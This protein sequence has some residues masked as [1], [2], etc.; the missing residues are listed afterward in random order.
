MSAETR[1]PLSSRWMPWAL[2]ALLALA[3][4]LRW[5]YLRTISLHVDEFTTLWAAEQVQARGLPLMPSGVLYTR[6]LLASYVEAIALWIGGGG[7]A[8]GRLPSLLF[9][10]GSILTVWMMGR[11]GWRAWV[12]L[13][14]AL[15]L[16]LLPEAVIWSGRARFY[17]QFQVLTL[18]AL[19]A[20]W[21]M[22]QSQGSET[23]RESWGRALT[24]AA[25]FALALFSQEQMVLLYPT[26]L[27]AMLAWRGGRWLL[28]PPVLAANA[29]ILVAM[30]ARLAIE[31][32]GQPGYFETIQ[33]S[34]PYV[35]LILDLR[36]AWRVYGPLLIEPARLPWTLGALLAAGTAIAAAVRARALR[37]LPRFHQST[38]YY[39]LQ[40]AG[41]LAAIFLLVGTSWRDTRY[42]YFVQPLLLLLGGAGIV[43][44]ADKLPTRAQV[45]ALGGAAALLLLAGL[46]GALSATTQ[47][48]EAYDKVL[49][50]V[51]SLRLEGDAVLSP[52][53]PAC[54]LVLGK[55][56]GYA[57][58]RG[59]EEFVIERD[60]HLVDRWTG[61]PLINTVEGLEA[62]VR[63][64]PHTW[65]VTDAFRLAT[66]YDADYLHALL[67]QFDMELQQQGVMAL[68]AE[69]WREPPAL[70]V[71][72]ELTPAVRFGPLA[73]VGWAHGDP[74]PGQTFPVELTWTGAEPVGAQINTS[75]RIVD[76]TGAIVA[77]QDGPPARGIIPTTLFFDTPL[78]DLKRLDLPEDLPAG[79]YRI[80]VVAYTVEDMQPQ[81]EIYAI[82]EFVV[83][84]PPAP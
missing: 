11:R 82:D 1:P 39:M 83:G 79:R 55:C 78:P 44:L 77:Q 48:V 23:R 74:N 14:A 4:W 7:Y 51:S 5:L 32:Y 61:A 80:D 67:A 36:G 37:A 58:Q 19:W 18:L 69:G 17:A 76:D 68:K 15:G 8:A 50:M 16:T 43:W 75:V 81:G 49:G 2:V 3:A 63:A 54:A 20:A 59:Y 64:A 29:I 38:L 57:I 66:R 42:L 60:G 13:L 35:G 22:I 72:Q 45:W 71:A 56:D 34:R 84:A 9:G 46:P 28:T 25:L 70:T 26:L 24:F 27:L 52:Q 21:E 62:I 53:P 31:I 10:L 73:L 6:G 65:F 30:A 41:V 47:Q 40:L 33:A 12:G